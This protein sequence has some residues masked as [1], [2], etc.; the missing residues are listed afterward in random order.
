MGT[1]SYAK[2]CGLQNRPLALCVSSVRLWRPD[3]TQVSTISPGD[4]F[5]VL[6]CDQIF[7]GCPV[8]WE[9]ASA[10]VVTASH[11]K[12]VDG[13][14][15]AVSNTKLMQPWSL[16]H[17]PWRVFRGGLVTAGCARPFCRYRA[18]P[19]L[20]ASRHCPGWWSTA[21]DL[22]FFFLFRLLGQCTVRV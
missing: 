21:L 1:L 13:Q 20:R 15:T 8:Q 7:N 4:R 19:W 10:Q 6:P 18:N 9:V 3:L 2:R 14:K 16:P 17:H 22:G 12:C 5:V 11:C